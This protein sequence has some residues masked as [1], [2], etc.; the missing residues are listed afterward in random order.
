[1]IN[2][3][4]KLT[5][6]KTQIFHFRPGPA[7]PRCPATF[8]CG[9][10][11]LKVVEKYRY[12]GL[13]L[14]EFIDYSETAKQVAAAAGRALGLLIAKSKAHGGMPYACFSHLY[15]ALV[16]SVINYGSAVWGDREF[17]CISAV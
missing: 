12:L 3:L 17:S 15:D 2:G 16:Q 9:G 4:Y 6:K 5:R 7:T 1:M 8:T 14:T 10:S 11:E 13:I